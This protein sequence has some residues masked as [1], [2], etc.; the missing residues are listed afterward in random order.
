VKSRQVADAYDKVRVADFIGSL[1]QTLDEKTAGV[2]RLY[3]EMYRD[4]AAGQ[5]LAV[6][7]DLE[8]MIIKQVEGIVSP[9]TEEAVNPSMNWSP[10][11][12]T[13]API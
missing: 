10:P 4:N 12:Q 3:A 11:V 13:Q 2:M 8:R 5:W 1:N 7:A 6:Q 9:S